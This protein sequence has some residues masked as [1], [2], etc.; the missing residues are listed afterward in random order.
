MHEQQISP[1]MKQRVVDFF[2]YLWIKNNGTERQ[3]LLTDMPYCMQADVSM[4]TIEPLMRNARSTAKIF[5][6][7][8]ILRFTPHLPKFLCRYRSL[9]RLMRHFFVT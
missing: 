4:A 2:D 5:F 9:Q 8:V 1:P 7:I 6:Q 3:T